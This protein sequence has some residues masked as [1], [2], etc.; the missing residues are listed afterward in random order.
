MSLTKSDLHWH[1]IYAAADVHF[2]SLVDE[3]FKS[4]R[5]TITVHFSELEMTPAFD[6]RAEALI[7][8]IT[9][10]VC[11]SNPSHPA[12]VAALENAAKEDAT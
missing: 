7:A 3:S 9:R 11:E 5:D 6:D 8:T 1:R 12:V 10:F 2:Q 4:V